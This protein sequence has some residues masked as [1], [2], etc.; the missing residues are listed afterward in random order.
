[1]ATETASTATTNSTVTGDLAYLKHHAILLAVVGML[2]LGGVY[3]VENLVARHD[4]NNDAK[5]QSILAAQTAQTQVL[6]K[7]LSTDEQNW[8]QIQASLLAQNA[9]LAAD[10]AKISQ[11][12]QEDVKHD[13]TLSA[14]EAA[15]RL[16]QQ[17]GATSGE[18]VVQGNA[19]VLDLPITRRIV[20]DLDLLAGTQATLSD[21]QKQLTNETVLFTNSQADLSETKKLVDSQQTQ[22][23]DADK[24]CKAEVAAIKAKH[25]KT[26]VK[27]A[28]ACLS[29]GFG[30]GVHYF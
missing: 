6:Q 25:R 21:T 29:I 18:V 3:G 24:A 8:A 30:I 7:Q 2:I 28:L 12:T 11:K 23:T 9:N 26:I 10:L 4:A 1:M 15:T 27:V 5:W 16:S 13:A 17:T 14:Q 19:V 20:G 22:L